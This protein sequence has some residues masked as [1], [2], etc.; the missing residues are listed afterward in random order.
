MKNLIASILALVTF[1]ESLYSI[2]LN[3]T[4]YYG[5]VNAPDYIDDDGD[6]TISALIYYEVYI[7]NGT[8]YSNLKGNESV[9]DVYWYINTKHQLSDGNISSLIPKNGAIISIS[10]AHSTT[11]NSGV[12]QYS[13]TYTGSKLPYKDKIDIHP[14]SWLIFNIAN[15]S[16]TSNSFSVTFPGSSSQW[17]GVG[18]AGKTVDLNISTSTQRRIEW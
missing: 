10:P 16:A 9:N 8:D 14:S 3:V 4:F 13:L 11:I 12:E 2:D 1:T 6:G 18:K 7:K 15:P 5:R 17:A